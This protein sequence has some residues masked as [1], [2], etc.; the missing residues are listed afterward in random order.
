MP[1]RSITLCLLTALGVLAAVPAPAQQVFNRHQ[2]V[3]DA[4]GKLLSWVQP[5]EQAYDRVMRLAWDFLLR[6][7]PVESNGLKTYLTYCCLDA[8]KLRA[9]RDWP[10]DPAST[11]AAFVDSALAYYAYS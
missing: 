6:T 11:F 9:T 8:K 5:Q 7:I 2:V 4:Q 10:H 1:R 3:L